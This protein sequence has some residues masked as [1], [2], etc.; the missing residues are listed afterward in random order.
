MKQLFS[1]I[2]AQALLWPLLAA[3]DT[4]APFLWQIKGKQATHYL[5]GS[6]HMLPATSQPLPPSLLTAYGKAAAVVFETDLAALSDAQT[7]LK[8]LS[9]A[10]APKGIRPIIGESL[11]KELRERAAALQLPLDSTCENY[12]PWFCAMTLEIVGFERAGFKP[13]YGL[14]QVFYTHA[15]DDN[16][17]IH[18]LEQPADHLKIFTTMP[19]KLATEFL[20][21][22]LQELGDAQQAPAEMLRMWREND[23]AAL[24]KITLE[25]KK[26]QPRA[27]ERLLAARTR[28]WIAPLQTMLDA[29]E[30][31]L[32]VVGAAHTVGPDG[33]LT[34]LRK[35][36]YEITP[37][38]AE[39]APVSAEAAS[40]PVES[41]SA[42]P[43]TTPP[44][45]REKKSP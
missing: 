3:A 40:T 21:S 15:S 16:K 45:P 4:N 42:P 23:V 24:E 10:D 36:G 28:A 43:Q 38:P 34:L 25:M 18:W 20:S 6:V 33:L 39:R 32:I 26:T 5:L 41:S 14:D 30:S 19:D 35:V 13:Q 27:Y 29:E 11:Y 44:A 8:M 12:K 22:T 2:L 31:Q 9:T 17:P 1:L 7:Q 37:V